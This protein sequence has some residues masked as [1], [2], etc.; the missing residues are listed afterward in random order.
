MQLG[1]VSRVCISSSCDDVVQAAEA[2]R[3]LDR[4]K[5][6]GEGLT[7]VVALYERLAGHY[8]EAKGLVRHASAAAT[9][10]QP[11]NGH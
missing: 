9:S 11:S 3:E 5:A 2:S 10:P 1:Y 6:A 7:V 4:A 8:N